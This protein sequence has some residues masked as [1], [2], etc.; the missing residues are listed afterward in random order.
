MIRFLRSGH[1]VTLIELMTAV[2]FLAIAGTAVYFMFVHGQA[3]IKEQLVRRR[4]LE[5]AQEQ[6]ERLKYLE[7]W[8]GNVPDAE[9]KSGRDTI[10]AA[11][12]EE[13][14]PIVADYKIIV[15]HSPTLD[16]NGRPIYDSVTVEYDWRAFSGRKYNIVLS[17]KY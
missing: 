17:T 10:Y 15:W 9:N 12:G 3:L 14:R 7:K 2:V 11:S 13:A 5:R 4:L 1:G 6:M 16:A 8:Y